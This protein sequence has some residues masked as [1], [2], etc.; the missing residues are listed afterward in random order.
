MHILHLPFLV[1][2]KR[3][4]GYW[5]HSVSDIDLPCKDNFVFLKITLRMPNACFIA[6]LF[7]TNLMVQTVLMRF[8]PQLHV[9]LCLVFKLSGQT[10]SV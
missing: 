6:C 7:N 3:I 5:H 2:T 8:V 4:L 1:F 10:S 9:C